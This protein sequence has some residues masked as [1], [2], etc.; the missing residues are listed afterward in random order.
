MGWYKGRYYTNRNN[1]A[2]MM[3][4]YF[5]PKDYHFEVINKDKADKTVVSFIF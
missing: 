4:N 1:L 2:Q 5:H 3:E